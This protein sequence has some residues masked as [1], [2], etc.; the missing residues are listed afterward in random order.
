M[1]IWL[2]NSIY[3]ETNYYIH[4]PP[5]N[6]NNFTSPLNEVEEIFCY[7]SR[8]NPWNLENPS[9]LLL[10][11]F[12][13]DRKLL[14]ENLFKVQITFFGFGIPKKNYKIQRIFQNMKGDRAAKNRKQSVDFLAIFFLISYLDLVLYCTLNHYLGAFYEFN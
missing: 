8:V 10:A 1:Q 7:H 12:I 2:I 14:F 3:T 11:R 5:K 6:N 9:I 13:T 4:T